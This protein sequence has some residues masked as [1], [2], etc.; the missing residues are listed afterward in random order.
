MIGT[1]F[2]FMLLPKFSE[3]YIGGWIGKGIS[4]AGPILLITGAGGAFGSILKSHTFN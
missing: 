1:L 4:L 3:K 2:A